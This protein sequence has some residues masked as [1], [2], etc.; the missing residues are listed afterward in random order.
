[1]DFGVPNSSN[2]FNLFRMLLASG[3]TEIYGIAC[4]SPMKTKKKI[5]I[6]APDYGP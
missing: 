5:G 2:S 1:M 4:Y 3:K 6:F